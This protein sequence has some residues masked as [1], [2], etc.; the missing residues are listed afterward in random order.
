MDDKKLFSLRLN[1]AKSH[2]TNFRPAL[3]LLLALGSGQSYAA[4]TYLNDNRQVNISGDDPNL[5][6]YNGVFT[7]ATPFA[8]FAHSNQ[9]SSLTST[10]F[11]ASGSGYAY[12]DYYYS[13][14]E[15]LFDVSFNLSTESSIDLTGYL[16]GMDENFGSGDASISLYSGTSTSAGSL[17]FSSSVSAVSNGIEEI[18]PAFND[19]LAAGDYRI[20]AI[21]NPYFQIANSSFSLQADF[22]P[23]VVPV[24]AAVWL[25]GS[26]LFALA[27]LAKR[28]KS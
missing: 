19:I 11:T 15:S 17:L 27:G 26:G 13:Y 9:T 1:S 14:T 24:P 2:S 25:F 20:V 3:C 18:F 8:D 4:V 6:V 10:G 7:P 28:K 12:S 23:T 16:Y 22:T 21:A 5:A